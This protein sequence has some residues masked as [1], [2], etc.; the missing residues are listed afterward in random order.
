MKFEASEVKRARRRR[1]TQTEWNGMSAL[2]HPDIW[3][4]G[5]ANGIKHFNKIRGLDLSSTA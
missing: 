4:G 5:I 3:K 1:A 2:C